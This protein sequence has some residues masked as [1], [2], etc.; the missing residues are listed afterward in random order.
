VTRWRHGLIIGKFR[1]PHTGHSFLIRTALE[2]VEK[3]TLIACS[4]ASDTIPAERR[5]GWLRELFPTVDV[6]VWDSGDHD[7]KD[8]ALWARLTQ[9][10]LP[11]SPDVVFTSEAYGEAYSRHL[12]CEHVCVD[13]NR[14][15]VPISAS[16]ILARPLAHL[17]YLEP[18]V[19]AHF[20]LRVVL[21]GAESTGKTT[22]ARQLADHY[23]T[24]WAPEYG[25][26]YWEGLLPSATAAYTS[27]DFVHIAQTQQ[28]MEDMLARHANRVLICDTDAFTTRL[29][30]ELYMGQDHDAPA[31]RHVAE[32]HRHALHILTGD[33]IAWED[34][35]TRDQPE[36]RHWFQGRFRKELTRS[37]RQ[38]VE[39]V[40]TPE[41]RL[42]AAV[43]AID[44]LLRD[45]GAP[46]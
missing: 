27:Q 28:A 4:H 34:D 18:P 31:V 45:G 10:W 29:W 42:A 11:G 41:Q 8:S 2:Q 30:H 46:V 36:R 19:R 26:P 13:P 40:G 35:G 9:E 25:R 24:A 33:E 1:P 39:V 23:R 3:L 37:G 22:L 7:P 21:V 17:D 44:E 14:A 32:G 16:Q 6:R 38:F 15:T 43:A 20:V 12:G 5:A